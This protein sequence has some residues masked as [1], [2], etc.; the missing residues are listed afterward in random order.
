MIKTYL[1]ETYDEDSKIFSLG[2]INPD[3]KSNEAR[4]KHLIFH[5]IKTYSI[6]KV[7]LTGDSIW[8]FIGIYIQGNY[9]TVRGLVDG[10][11][12]S[13]LNDNKKSGNINC[14]S[15]VQSHLHRIITEGK[16]NTKEL[17]VLSLL[18]GQCITTK[19]TTVN[20]NS[21]TT[22]SETPKSVN[23]KK[24]IDF[25]ER[26]VTSD[27]II[28]LEKLYGDGNGIHSHTA[29]DIMI[30]SMI[31]LP[32][33]K[34][35]KLAKDLGVISLQSTDKSPLFSAIICSE[36]FQQ[37][38]PG[39]EEK[40]PF[41]KQKVLEPSNDDIEMLINIIPD[42]S[43]GK[44]KSILK[45]N[46]NNVETVTNMLLEEPELINTIEEGEGEGE[47]EE[48][49]AIKQ[50]PPPPSKSLVDRFTNKNYSYT[51]FEKQTNKQIL[52]EKNLEIALRSMYESDEDEP[53]DTYEEGE[54][55][56]KT[57]PID[58]TER[59]LF[60]QFKEKGIQEFE[61]GNRKSQSR[62]KMK[63]EF[64]WSDEQI[65]GWMKMLMKTPKRFKMLEEDYLYDRG[66]GMSFSDSFRRGGG[67]GGEAEEED[68]EKEKEKE[69]KEKEKGDKEKEKGDKKK[70][71]NGNKKENGDNKEHKKED[72]KK[73]DKKTVRKPNR[74]KGSDF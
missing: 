25:A 51:K 50:K 2:A 63:K 31:S 72:K 39:I 45:D 10:S 15:S 66:G 28:S 21:A 57:S 37:L 54:L 46:E 67:G 56:N 68:K 6:L 20:L 65:E 53:D 42:L 33:A 58:E 61:R 41:V 9:S 43:V 18:L 16:F 8:Y 64:E 30:I 47:E 13:K 14:I 71:N 11:F 1:Y 34:V 73:H 52:K 70:H 48:E 12:K 44:A 19:Y 22:T 29:K 69:D 59:Q 27:W 5:F 32:G 4:L 38:I 7:N 49:E 17:N 26:F 3:I 24:S 35:V 36:Q 62:Q 40:L 74:K 60:K 23:K 55:G